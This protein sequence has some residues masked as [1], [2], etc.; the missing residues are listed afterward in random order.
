M[1]LVER[2]SRGFVL[3]CKKFSNT[4]V[5]WGNKR[6][7]ARKEKDTDSLICSKVSQ[8]GVKRVRRITPTYKRLEAWKRGTKKAKD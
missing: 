3:C 6:Y 4:R 7:W 5:I 8:L 2:S 1:S